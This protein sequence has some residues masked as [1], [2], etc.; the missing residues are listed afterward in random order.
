[1]RRG[2]GQRRVAATSAGPTDSAGH[3]P[4]GHVPLLW[5]H[6]T[7]DDVYTLFLITLFIHQMTQVATLLD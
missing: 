6:V 7:E 2:Q 1:M 4:E 5:G 3:A